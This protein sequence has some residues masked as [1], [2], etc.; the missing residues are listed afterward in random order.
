MS[1][2]ALQHLATQLIHLVSLTS[3]ITYATCLTALASG[4]VGAKLGGEYFGLVVS[5]GLSLAVISTLLALG[6]GLS[7]LGKSEGEAGDVAAEA[8]LGEE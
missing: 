4:F 2:R 8:G 3:H 6:V 7:L 1:F 5:N